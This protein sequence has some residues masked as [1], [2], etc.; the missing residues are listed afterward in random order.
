MDP[1][2]AAI[3]VLVVA[4]AA[5]G[6]TGA[7]VQYQQSKQ[8][9]RTQEKIA[10]RNAKAAEMEARD[11]E[12]TARIN[13]RREAENQRREQARRR[14]LYGASGV[15]L[16]SGSPLALMA[17]AASDNA[18]KRSDIM[19]LG[20]IKSSSLLSEAESH[21][22]QGRVAKKS[23]MSKT[24][25]GLRLTSTWINAGKEGLSAVGSSTTK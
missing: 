17:E 10:N 6:T 22:M 8:N 7:L 19:R 3:L 4:G 11:A 18:T 15:A 20:V 14:A 25:L 24:E 23:R 12:N 1:I 13:A 5:T 2:T 21:R 9:A 16:D